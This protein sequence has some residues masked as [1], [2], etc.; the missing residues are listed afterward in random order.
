MMLGFSNISSKVLVYLHY[1][2][3]AHTHNIMKEESSV[4]CNVSFNDITCGNEFMVVRWLLRQCI[5]V[6]PQYLCKQVLFYY[7]IAVKIFNEKC[8]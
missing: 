7:L 1:S 4:N 3:T 5:I 6:Q 8:D 2:Y